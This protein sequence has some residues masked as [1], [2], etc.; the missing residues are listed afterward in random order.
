[1]GKAV[2]I[3]HGTENIGG[4]GRYLADW[5]RERKKAVADFMVYHDETNRQNSHVNLHLERLNGWNRWW[6]QWH[7]FWACLFRYD[8]FHFYFGK[9]FLPFGLDLPI[10]KL[11]GKKMVFS[12]VGSDI[13]LYEVDRHRNPYHELR[14]VGRQHP[15]LDGRKKRMMRWQSLWFDR[16]LASRN[17]YEYAR[18][19][20]P[21][22]KI[23]RHIW[24]NTA[25]NLE[26]FVPNYETKSV[27]VIV[28]APTNPITKGTPYIE[29]ALEELKAEGYAFEYRKLHKVPN[30]EARRI[31]REEADIIVDQLLSGGF[32]T[33]AMEAM[34]YGK[35]V[36][37]FV[38]PELRQSLPDL[39][40]VQ[41]TIETIKQQLI[42]LLEHPEERVQLGRAGRAFAE[43]H[44]D[45]EKNYQAVWDLYLELLGLPDELP[46]APVR[47]AKPAGEDE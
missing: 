34:C 9:T 33:L 46:D 26:E 18:A 32:G 16:C 31:Y 47:A 10:L 14:K 4:I 38:L 5:Q 43:A 27:P 20:I 30:L 24:A 45:R 37:G 1:M 6:T 28:H 3:F 36:C 12:Y 17:L 40:I 19:V 21:E 8:L 2:R 35:P 11:F 42:W 22:K 39:P 23:V 13:R 29:Q 15:R 41:C 44:Y 25:M 7:F